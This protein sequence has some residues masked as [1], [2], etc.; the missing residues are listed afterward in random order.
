[1]IIGYS[2]GGTYDLYARLMARFLANYIPGNPVIV[3][4]NMPGGGS[5]T[6]TAWVYSAA[7]KDGSV[8]ATADQSLAIAQALGDP[9]IRFD[10][11]KL[12]YI[13]NPS[14]ENNTTVAWHTSGIRTIEDATKQEVTVG[15]TGGSTSSQYPKAMNALLGTKFKIILGY[16]GGNDI[17]IAL[18]RGE[19][20][21]R[22]SNTWQSWKSTRADWLRDKKINILVQIGLNK[23]EDLP[24]VPLLMDLAK[25]DQDRAVLK[26]LSSPTEIGRPI[27]TTPDTP[28][29][30]VKIL[31]DAFDTMVADPKFVEE[32][33]RE[34]FEIDPVSGAQMQKIVAD[35]VASPKNIT[36][37]LNE[38]IGEVEQNT[39]S[40]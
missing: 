36:Q 22:G 19:V 27:F 5:R 20:A 11:N 38:I 28:A 24:D 26:L 30:R 3:P 16:P 21:V 39:S 31:R 34:K 17:N 37:R 4:R 15:A 6:A 23:A 10:V 40:K 14:R 1:M 29:D 8:L 2:S 35:I 25:N 33:K 32:A 13:G 9:Q 18:E 7:P 12:I